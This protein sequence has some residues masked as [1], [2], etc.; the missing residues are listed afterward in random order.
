MGNSNEVCHFQNLHLH[1]QAG[2]GSHQIKVGPCETFA[3]IRYCM[4]FVGRG[5]SRVSLRGRNRKRANTL[6]LSGRFNST[7]GQVCDRRSGG[8]IGV[9]DGG[10]GKWWKC[11]FAAEQR[12]LS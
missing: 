2:L 3:L 1:Y 8:R 10:R 5:I 12:L 11:G 7:E 9:E 6:P 4:V